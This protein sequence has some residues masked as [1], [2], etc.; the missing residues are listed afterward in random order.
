VDRAVRA[1]AEAL[2]AW[3]AMPTRDRAALV[4]RFA[5]RI[6]DQATNIAEEVVYLVEAEPIRHR[7]LGRSKP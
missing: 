6:A 2:P 4:A 3:R 5:E 1:A 7:F